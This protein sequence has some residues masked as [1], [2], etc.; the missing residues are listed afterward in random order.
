MPRVKARR[1]ACGATGST[2]GSKC[3]VR[4]RRNCTVR[5]RAMMW[6]MPPSLSPL[7]LRKRFYLSKRNMKLFQM[8]NMQLRGGFCAEANGSPQSIRGNSG[9][10]TSRS[11]LLVPFT[12]QLFK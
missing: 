4:E 8:F 1:I 7:A 10:T 3:T 6:S 9:S 11:T 2:C 5:E 12:E